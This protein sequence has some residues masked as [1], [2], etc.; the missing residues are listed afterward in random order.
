MRTVTPNTIKLWV[1]FRPRETKLL[2]LNSQLKDIIDAANPVSTIRHRQQR[3][4]NSDIP[5]A[6]RL[7][8]MNVV[9]PDIDSM[10]PYQHRIRIWILL[11]GLLQ[12]LG[13]VLL[14]R[15]VFND[16]DPES[17]IVSKIS[18]LASPLR[19]ALDL[20][21]LLNLE[22]RVFADFTFYEEGDEDGPLRVCVNAA[23]GAT[24]EGGVEEG[25][26]GRGFVCLVGKSVWS[27]I[28]SN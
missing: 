2:H 24:L 6:L 1:S 23:A 11:H 26:T 20:L 18:L 25:G 19:N 8:L 28:V 10:P 5:F 7:C 17:I 15:R 27:V 22:A 16:R 9:T 4:S 21:N 14:M 3:V 13:Q 12:A